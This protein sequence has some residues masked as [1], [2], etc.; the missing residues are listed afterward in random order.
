[1]GS[2]HKEALLLRLELQAWSDVIGRQ[3]AYY[4]ESGRSTRPDKEVGERLRRVD[5]EIIRAYMD[6]IHGL[7]M[8][9]HDVA[10]LEELFVAMDWPPLVAAR[11]KRAED[12]SKKAAS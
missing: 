8:S 11:R 1:M 2:R 3:L 9:V 6:H 12:D 4:F 10:K 5:S 7:G